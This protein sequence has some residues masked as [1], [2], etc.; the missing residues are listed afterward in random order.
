MERIRSF[1]PQVYGY[2]YAPELTPRMQ[3][4]PQGWRGYIEMLPVRDLD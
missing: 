4:E 2:Q 1:N 3:L